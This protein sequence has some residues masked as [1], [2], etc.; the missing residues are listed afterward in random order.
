MSQLVDSSSLSGG[1]QYVLVWP[2]TGVAAI[3]FDTFLRVDVRAEGLSV[4]APVE[5]GSFA[6]YNKITTPNTIELHVAKQGSDDILQ[7]TLHTLDTLQSTA[8]LVNLITPIA[9]YVGYTVE[10]YDF[11]ITREA[12]LGVIY[13][14]IRLIEVREVEPQ[15]TDAQPISTAGAKN[16]SDVSTTDRGKQTV[17]DQSNSTQYASVLSR[18][19]GNDI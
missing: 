5:A 8:V 2:D 10:S 16:S 11:A 7:Q 14:R 4:S 13:V 15:Y 6:S 9:E 1:Y 3:E 18:I 12:G 19:W 17:Q